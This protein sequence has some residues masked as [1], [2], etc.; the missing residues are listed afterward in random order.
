MV[1]TSPAPPCNGE[2]ELSAADHMDSLNH[3]LNLP[4]NP[5]GPGEIKIK[6]KITITMEMW[7]G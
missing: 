6:S 3:N 2:R 5:F 4:L 1:E 7:Q